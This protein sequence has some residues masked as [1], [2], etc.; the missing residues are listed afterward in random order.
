MTVPLTEQVSM[1]SIS[2]RVASVAL[3]VFGLACGSD[4]KGTGPDDQTGPMT[5]LIDGES[6][7]AEFATV[8]QAGGQVYVNGAALPQR[9]I[10]F[11]FPT[12]GVGTYTMAVGQLV[13]AGV[14]IGNDAWIAG[15]G[16]GG[17]TITVT[18][19]TAD[20]LVGTFQLS[21]VASGGQAPQTL[22]VTNGKFDISY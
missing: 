17:G 20:R 21:V 16:S 12:E 3:L 11:T 22:S 18:T 6:F 10:G 2:L 4:D 5:A 7:V 19:F 14:T 1:P 15:S 13:A 9:A 8:D